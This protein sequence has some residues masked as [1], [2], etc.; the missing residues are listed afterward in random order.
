VGR[1]HL[2]PESVHKL[3]DRINT[4]SRDMTVAYGTYSISPKLSDLGC[5]SPRGATS[6]LSSLTIGLKSGEALR[7]PGDE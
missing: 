3:R 7:F 1:H 2:S 5:W 4:T 6:H